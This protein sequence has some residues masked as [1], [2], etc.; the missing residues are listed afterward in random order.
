MD[1][2]RDRTTIESAARPRVHHRRP[3]DGRVCAGA[4][5]VSSSSWRASPMSRTRR[6]G[7]FCRHRRSELADCFGSRGWQRRPFRFP[8]EDVERTYRTSCRRRT[9]A[10]PPA[11]RRARTRTPRCPCACRP[12]G[13]APAPGSCRPACRECVRPR[14]R[15]TSLMVPASDPPRDRRA[16]GLARPKSS[17][18]ARTSL[19]RPSSAPCRTML[20]GF[21]S[22]WTMPFSCAA[23]SASAICRAMA[24]ACG[25][26]NGAALEA[27]GQRLALR[28][29]RAPA[30]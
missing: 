5:S 8:F 6:P 9:A 20:A 29:V 3:R 17:T 26:G 21:R 7:S 11:S 23:S 28:P 27:I 25:I 18:F 13:R 19:D 1:T 16:I 22:R 30:R 24:S 12:P 2:P 15:R 4:S 14:C 10:R